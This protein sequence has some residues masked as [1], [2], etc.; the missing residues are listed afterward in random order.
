MCSKSGLGKPSNDSRPPA[1]WEGID[2]AI[3]RLREIEETLA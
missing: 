1:Y 2:A 3:A